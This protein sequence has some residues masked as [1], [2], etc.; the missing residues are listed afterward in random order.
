MSK[1]PKPKAARIF[2]TAD[3]K[4]R[5]GRPTADGFANIKA[6]LGVNPRGTP[7]GKNNL[8]S[9][10]HY[11]F[12]LITRD[13]IQL[14]AAYRG[15]WIVGRVINCIAEDMTRAGIDIV[16]NE[17]AED[18]TEFQVQMSRLQIWPSL[19]KNISW[20]R[21]YGG[22]CAVFQIKGQNLASPMDVDTIGKGQF[23]GF[24]VYDRWQLYPVL[25]KLIDSG[26]D[27]GL[28]EFYDVVLGTNLNDPSKIQGG[29]SE[30][31]AGSAGRVRVHHSRVIRHLGTELP[32]WQA[33]TEMLWG[34]SIL[35]QMWDRLIEFD[36]ATTSASGLV[37]KANLRMIGINGLREIIAAGGEELEALYQNFDMIAEFQNNEGLT[38]L[39]KEDEYNSSQYSFAGLPDTLLKLAEQISGAADIPM[40]RLF[41]QS[42]SGLGATGDSDIRQYYDGIQSKQEAGMRNGIEK[43][44]KI[45]WQS[46]F[47]RPC[48][49]YLTFTFKPLWQMSAKDKSDIAKANTETLIEAHDAGGISNAVLVKELKQQSSASGLFTH[50]TDEDVKDAED[51]DENPP[52]LAPTPA[53]PPG[54]TTGD[55]G[56]GPTNPA[57]KIKQAT[58]DSAWKKIR[59]YVRGK[60]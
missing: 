38:L 4:V 1:T 59:D 57:D 21:L 19:R 10:G 18:V 14:E 29:N 28:P 56:E 39:D 60:K 13:R 35:E 15:S 12:N 49:S 51:L 58:G 8:M 55:P 16:T 30:T 5:K 7:G 3:K 22:S 2:P 36:T 11:E 24:T 26:P 53:G 9:Q 46:Y 27:L 33:I 42:P 40:V 6:R 48:P 44:V 23:L 37:F 43:V 41:G 45:L 54:T 32:F 50:I 52:E 20:G 31:D 17:G 47:G 34:S 25:D